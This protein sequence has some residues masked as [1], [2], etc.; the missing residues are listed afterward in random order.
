MWALWASRVWCKF[1][2]HQVTPNEQNLSS[3]A[4]VLLGRS[5]R[6]CVNIMPKLGQRLVFSLQKQ[7]WCW[8]VEKEYQW[9]YHPNKHNV[10]IRFKR[11]NKAC[12][13][14]S[15]LN[16]KSNN[17]LPK[18]VRECVFMWSVDFGIGWS[19]PPAVITSRPGVGYKYKMIYKVK[20]Q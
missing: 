13:I 7:Q 14:N 3:T 8:F 4:S 6:F 10:L 5:R 16:K 2:N 9:S 1:H 18:I 17:N 11:Q 12:I 20:Q 19:W 15:I